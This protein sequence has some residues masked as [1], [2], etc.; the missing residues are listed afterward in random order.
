M[1]VNRCSICN[2]VSSPSVATNP[3]DYVAGMFSEDPN[4]PT[5]MVCQE[6]VTILGDIDSE[7]LDDVE[8][9][10]GD[11]DDCEE[12]EFDEWDRDFLFDDD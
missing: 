6:C 9:E 4:D 2:R 1:N 11:L 10:M 7:W 3:G 12:D 5:K 8:E